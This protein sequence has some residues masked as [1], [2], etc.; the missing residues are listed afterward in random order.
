MS[1]QHKPEEIGHRAPIS[2]VA[3]APNGRLWT[4]SYD[5]ALA[6]WLE[7]ETGTWRLVSR[8]LLHSKGVNCLAVDRTGEWVITG[9]SDGKACLVRTADTRAPVFVLHHA[10]DVE[11]V[12]F[13][14]AG[15]QV[16][17]GGTDG[18]A[19]I[20]DVRGARLLA[21]VHH[22]A[23]VGAACQP[24]DERYVITGC[25]DA[26]LRK[27]E[28]QTGA[29]TSVHEAHVGPVKALG[30]L[31]T[32]VL[33][34]SHDKRI[35]VWDQ[36]LREVGS[37]GSF[38][39]TPKA[40]ATEPDGLHYWVA[41]YDQTISRWR[42][43]GTASR[44]EEQCLFKVT[45][46]R[47]WAHG[48]SAAG[49]CVAV[50][51]FD[52]RPVIYQR[53]SNDTF[54]K[55]NLNPQPVDCV[56]SMLVDADACR[57]L[58]SGD[59]GRFRSLALT[60]VSS[61]GAHATGDQ[62]AVAPAAVTKIVGKEDD[63]SFGCW[64]GT[65]GRFVHG[66]IEWIADEGYGPAPVH[67]GSPVVSIAR[68]DAYTLAALYTGGVACFSTSTGKRLWTQRTA[69]GATKSVSTGGAMYAM[70]GRYD[71]LRMGRLD[72]GEIVGHLRLDTPVSDVVEFAQSPLRLAVASHGFEVWVVDITITEWAHRLDVIHRGDGHISPVKA[73]AWIDDETVVSGC[74]GGRI[75]LHR[76]G[77][78]SICLAQIDSRL[79]ISALGRDNSGLLYWATFDG[80]VGTISRV[81]LEEVLALVG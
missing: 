63:F 17:T 48:I 13:S 6:E 71:P 45:D 77:R 70:T 49:N 12:A 24:A 3:I 4:V 60:S 2:A 43:T 15:D 7:E 22:G 47:A 26:R 9:G 23:T 57:V 66:K 31:G 35:L 16:L 51:S 29:V 76:L 34:S 20:F 5:G 59:S 74:Y 38:T 42:F 78:P 8:R 61:S 36:D 46:P 11:T 69:S 75:Y 25:N 32:Y 33:S 53:S 44:F 81:H 30:A 62:V 28:W 19:R 18:T 65:I 50:G 1:N 64:D 14:A 40:L 52:D 21:T 41:A 68:S 80:R 37:V 39:T 55:V 58:V 56:S 73:L 54:S 67:L 10:G 79:G 72:T 27:I